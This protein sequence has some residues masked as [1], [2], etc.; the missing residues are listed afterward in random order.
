MLLPFLI[1]DITKS[2]SPCKLFEYMALHKP[3]VTTDINECRKYKSVLIGQSH[4]DF[5]KQIA[6][7]LKLKENQ[8]YWQL[9]DQEAQANDWSKKAQIIVDLI[10]KDE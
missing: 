6:E 10:K 8:N 2:T 9:L 3:I 1:C 4:Q 7:A 5:L